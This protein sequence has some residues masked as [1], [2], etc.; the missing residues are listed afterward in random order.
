[1]ADLENIVKM[2]F[3]SYNQNKYI[4]LCMFILLIFHFSLI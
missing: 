3:L 4:N 1:M 2:N